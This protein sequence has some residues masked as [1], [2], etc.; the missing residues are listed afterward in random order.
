MRKFGSGRS[1]DHDIGLGGKPEGIDNGAA[2][3][4]LCPDHTGDM[5]D[6]T[7]TQ[8]ISVEPGCCRWYSVCM[9]IPMRDMVLDW[10][11]NGDLNLKIV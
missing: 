8:Q 11:T 7:C 2:M 3:I 10:N 6:L 9:L 5:G 1:P 4:E